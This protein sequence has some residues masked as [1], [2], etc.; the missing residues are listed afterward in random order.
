ML[1][2]I[3]KWIGAWMTPIGAAALAAIVVSFFESVWGYLDML[4]HTTI[5]CVITMTGIF[6]YRSGHII[7]ERRWKSLFAENYLLR[8]CRGVTPELA[9]EEAEERVAYNTAQEEGFYS[10]VGVLGIL[11]GLFGMLMVTGAIP[12]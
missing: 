11:V 2:S 1:G 4:E 3:A 7:K 5:W 8:L 10:F 6:L 12:K 9:Q